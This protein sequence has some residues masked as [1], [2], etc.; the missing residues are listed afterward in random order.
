MAGHLVDAGVADVLGHV[1]GRR[2]HGGC[3]SGLLAIQPGVDAG[4]Q[5]ALRRL[6]GAGRHAQELG[7]DDVDDLG[8]QG[9]ALVDQLFQNVGH[10]VL[11]A[12]GDVWFSDVEEGGEELDGEGLA[13]GDVGHQDDGFHRGQ[14]FQQVEVLLMIRKLGI[15]KALEAR[16]EAFKDS[17][18]KGML[19]LL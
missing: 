10:G 13:V 5:G 18:K 4:G 1:V 16:D 3:E 8:G 11:Y 6:D 17:L 19:L 9:I 2:G 12:L 14:G 7:H 15:I